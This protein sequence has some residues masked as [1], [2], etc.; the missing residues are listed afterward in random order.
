MAR[1]NQRQ[2]N[3]DRQPRKTNNKEAL[4]QSPDFVYGFHAAM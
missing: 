2:K 4:D 1:N 3:R